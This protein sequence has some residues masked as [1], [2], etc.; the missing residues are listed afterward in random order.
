MKK[1]QLQLQLV[2]EGI[3]GTITVWADRPWATQGGTIVGS[4]TLFAN[5]P[6]QSTTVIIDVPALSKLKGKHALYFTFSSETKGQSL[7]SLESLVF[8]G[9]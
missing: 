2:P 1:L 7:C 8:A 9:K 3:D 5:M 6:Q 4:A